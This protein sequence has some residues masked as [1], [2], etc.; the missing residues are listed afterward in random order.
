MSAG[1]DRR[2]RLRVFFF[3]RRG[4]S[5]MG[6]SLFC[7]LAWKIRESMLEQGEFTS[8]SASDGIGSVVA[9]ART[10]IRVRDCHRDQAR[11]C[12][13]NASNHFFR[14]ERSSSTSKYLSQRWSATGMQ[15]SPVQQCSS[16]K[17]TSP[18]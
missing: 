12:R 11:D 18:L 10:I 1:V 6:G 2:N 17:C 16:Q 14:L 4:C 8:V 9:S 7:S 3:R 5:Y 13:G 15:Q